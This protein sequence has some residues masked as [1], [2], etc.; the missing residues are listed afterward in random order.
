LAKSKGRRASTMRGHGEV[1]IVRER[2]ADHLRL[3]VDLLFHEVAVVA[4]VDQEGGAEETAARGRSTGL[5]SMSKIW[6]PVAAIT[7]QSPSSR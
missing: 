1:E 7:A 2:V 6:A 3:L 5:P 4:L